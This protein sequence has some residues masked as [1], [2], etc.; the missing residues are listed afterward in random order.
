MG[1][2]YGA[3]FFL[4]LELACSMSFVT[5]AVYDD[6]WYWGA[7]GG[8]LFLLFVALAG[9]IVPRTMRS[10][11]GGRLRTARAALQL[12][13]SVC[14][15]ELFIMAL[16]T[17]ALGRRHLAPSNAY[18][19]LGLLIFLGLAGVGIQ[20]VLAMTAYFVDVRN[21]S[22][23]APSRLEARG[24]AEAPGPGPDRAH[25]SLSGRTAEM[26]GA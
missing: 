5:L 3:V 12:L 15:L 26:P 23:V 11:S 14:G 4:V 24:S 16:V 7:V 18:E 20:G 8:V 13:G 22:I 25:G 10:L 21:R 19:V 1:K 9:T 17:W 6:Q 2:V